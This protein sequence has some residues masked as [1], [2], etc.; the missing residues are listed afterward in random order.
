[1]R[2]GAGLPFSWG[3]TASHGERKRG[4]SQVCVSF[5]KHKTA[6]TAEAQTIGIKY[7]RC[8]LIFILC[9]LICR[10]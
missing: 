10:V 2:L 8:E 3:N 7:A 6:S 1:M 5:M 9:E 4:S